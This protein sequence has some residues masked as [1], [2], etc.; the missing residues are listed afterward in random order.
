MGTFVFSTEMFDEMPFTFL[1]HQRLSEPEL[2]GD[3]VYKF[4][5]IMGGT[6][7]CDKLR[8]NIFKWKSTF[9]LSLWGYFTFSIMFCLLQ[10]LVIVYLLILL[11]T[12][13]NKLRVSK[14]VFHLLN[15]VLYFQI[16]QYILCSWAL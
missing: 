9:F 13:Q 4:E 8:F 11:Y 14:Y 7:F 16:L 12:Q 15:T 5:N 1:L 3:L 6:D 2:Y 10:F